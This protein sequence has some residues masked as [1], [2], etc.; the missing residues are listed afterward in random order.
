[1]ETVKVDLLVIGDMM[2]SSY[3]A[4]GLE[5]HIIGAG[6]ITE[7][8][9]SN[10]P[11]SVEVCGIHYDLRNAIVIDAT[12]K[13]VKVISLFVPKGKVVFVSG[14]ASSA[15][16]DKQFDTILKDSFHNERRLTIAAMAMQGMLSNTTRFSSYEISDL[17]RISLNCADALIAEA[18][19]GGEQ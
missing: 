2:T 10:I 8:T 14:I 16:C 17:V 6:N 5:A 3:M 13:P 18:E 19:K 4:C 9:P 11:D 12:E 7:I 1:M 15:N